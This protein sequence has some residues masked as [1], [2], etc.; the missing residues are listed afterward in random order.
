MLPPQGTVFAA[1]W[2][3]EV[4][5]A[6]VDELEPPMSPAQRAEY[7][8]VLTA[9]RCREYVIA[10]DG[11]E[12]KLQAF[13][14]LLPMDTTV[15]QIHSLMAHLLELLAHGQ[16]NSVDDL[17]QETEYRVSGISI[18]VFGADGSVAASLMACLDDRLDGREIRRV[19]DEMLA[20]SRTVREHQGS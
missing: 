9:I 11:A 2:P 13:F 17:S 5:D 16:L 15:G 20:R 10:L 4:V 14:D 7:H 6:W 19:T 12:S 8:E 18:P 3:P 1:W